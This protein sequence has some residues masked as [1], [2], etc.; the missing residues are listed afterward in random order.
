MHTNDLLLDRRNALQGTDACLQFF[1][2]AFTV[3]FDLSP[4][5]T[6]AS[7][8]LQSTRESVI[9]YTLADRTEKQDCSSVTYCFV[10]L[11]L[12]SDET[13]VVVSSV[14]DLGGFL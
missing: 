3:L 10:H 14:G 1:V 2:P 9:W 6:P 13:L 5:I 11:S 7:L 8:D 4:G 12:L